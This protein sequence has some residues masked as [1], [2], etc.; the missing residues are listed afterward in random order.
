[1]N[2]TDIVKFLNE[3]GVLPLTILLFAF[4]LGSLLTLVIIRR[5]LLKDF[6]FKEAWN[7]WLADQRAR[8]AVEVKLEERIRELVEEVKH[9]VTSGLDTRRYVEQVLLQTKGE[10]AQILQYLEDILTMS[11]RKIVK[12]EHEDSVPSPEPS[13]AKVS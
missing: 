4:P 11:G 12:F 10:H 1:M 13:T 2:W 7:S 3:M 6:S 9:L 5:V 8:T